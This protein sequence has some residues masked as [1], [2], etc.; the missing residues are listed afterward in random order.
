MFPE[1]RRVLCDRYADTDAAIQA[2]NHREFIT[3]C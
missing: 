2:I 1:A 3:I